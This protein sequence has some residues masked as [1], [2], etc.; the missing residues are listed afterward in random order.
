M[1]ESTLKSPAPYNMT[2]AEASKPTKK[3]ENLRPVD[4]VCGLLRPD[5]LITTAVPPNMRSN[6]KFAGAHG[7]T[8]SQ[9][10]TLNRGPY[11][12]DDGTGR[13]HANNPLT[14]GGMSIAGAP[15]PRGGGFSNY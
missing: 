3:F 11:M 13:R 14:Q 6:P 9:L 8:T 1:S 12:M 5:L 10:T 2:T 7:A 4:Q 15:M